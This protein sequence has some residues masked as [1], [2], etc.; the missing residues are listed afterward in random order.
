MNEHEIEYWNQQGPAKT[1]THPV[2]I[3][4][5]HEY[6]APGDKVLDYGCGYGRVAA[7]LHECG[8]QVV[9][10]DPAGAMIEKARRLHPQ[11]SFHQIVPPKLPFDDASFDAAVLMAVLTCIPSDDDQRAVLNEVHRVV[12][13][14]G[15]LYVSDYWLQTDPR[16]VARYD[17]HELRYRT[18][19][20]FE[21]SEGVAVR[22]HSRPWI[23]SLLGRWKPIAEADIRVATMNGHEAAGFQR[24]VGRLGP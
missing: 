20:V 3:D 14:G 22:H 13:P 8:Y 10:V 23:D 9:G 11:P 15:L 2:R 6:L 24:L 17:Q 7:L 1:F 19:G 5:L 18:Y 16:N 4:W 21:V 12:R